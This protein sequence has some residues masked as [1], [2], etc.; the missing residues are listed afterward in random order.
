MKSK[1]LVFLVFFCLSRHCSY[2][3]ESE[4][5]N[6]T[7]GL[8]KFITWI[9]DIDKVL[10][11]IENKENLNALN[12]NLGYISLYIDQLANSKLSLAKEISDL[13]TDKKDKE[14]V[15][16]LDNRIH[17]IMAS[18]DG[19]EEYLKRVK[20]L[21][22]QT[23]QKEIDDIILEIQKGLIHRKLYLLE[24]IKQAIYLKDIPYDRIVKE[25]QESK[26]IADNAL[27]E[28]K[29]AKDLVMAAI[30]K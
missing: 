6:M 17:E 4:V 27:R 19:L 7:S 29:R 24:D 5:S 3:Q 25:S 22:S 14:H 15:P 16:K 10:I 13:K 9:S 21:L 8:S 20:S 12:R 1:L 26:Q 11:G 18:I 28:I 23:N 30:L 2:S